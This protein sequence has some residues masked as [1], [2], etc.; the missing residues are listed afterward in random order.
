MNDISL[1]IREIISETVKG[2]PVAPE[3]VKD[4]MLLREGLGA[5]SLEGVELAITIEEDFGI[6]LSDEAMEEILTVGDLVAA[7][8]AR[9]AGK[10]G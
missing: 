2:C 5:D 7:V 8:E 9:V 10:A 1:R 3:K 6:E 4:D